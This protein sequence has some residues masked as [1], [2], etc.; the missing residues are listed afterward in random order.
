MSLTA[1]PKLIELLRQERHTK[2]ER[3]DTALKA[4][5]AAIVATRGYEARVSQEG[6]QNRQEEIEIGELWTMA[7]FAARQ[8]NLEVAGQLRSKG[9]LY[10]DPDLM[11]TPEELVERRIDWQSIHASVEELL[12]S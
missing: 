4:I 1:L 5:L 3:V 2:Q 12:R 6:R 11:W 8:V 7:S 9:V 10:L